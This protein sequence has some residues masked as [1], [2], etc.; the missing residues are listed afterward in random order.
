M[1]N[2][3]FQELLYEGVL[4]NYM[5]DFVIL[6]KTM[7]KLEERMIRFLKIAEKHNLCFKRLKYDFN[8]EE[9][10]ILGVI[11]EKG[12]VKME[13]E[14]IKAVEEWKT[15]TRIKN[16][17]SFL[18][19]ANFY[20]QFIQNFSHTAKPLN[21]LKGKKDWK[22]EEKHQKGFK[23][24]KEN[25]TSQLVLLLPRRE[26]KF[27][28]E[29]DASGHAIGE[30]LFQEQDG[31]WKPIAFLSRTM[32]PAERNYEI[33]DKELLA[34]MEALIKWRQYLL[35]A[36]E[37]FEIWTDYENLKYFWEPHKLNRRQAR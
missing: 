21:K 7:E 1:I 36:V 10:P 30:V 34:I 25:I 19:F 37:T 35:D 3:I 29:T 4:A 23:K 13:Q 31:K 28:V 24:L 27:R 6:A 17:E 32:Q 22:W 8:I 26:G 14:K 33:H 9:I 5:D 16:V 2:S 12:Q 11:V 15:L 18:G 20:Q